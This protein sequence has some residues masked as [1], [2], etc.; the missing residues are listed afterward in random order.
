MTGTATGVKGARAQEA[1]QPSAAPCALPG[2]TPAPSARPCCSPGP[3]EPPLAPRGP[4]VARR[5]LRARPVAC[6]CSR[7]SRRQ[8]AELQVHHPK[9]LISVKMIGDRRLRSPRKIKKEFS[10]KWASSAKGTPRAQAPHPSTCQARSGVLA[11]LQGARGLPGGEENAPGTAPGAGGRPGSPP[12]QSLDFNGGKALCTFFCTHRHTHACTHTLFLFCGV[13]Y[14]RKR[15]T[16]P[17]TISP[18]VQF[19]N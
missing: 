13:I 4:G 6:W 2:R 18:Q 12:S 9:F 5:E 19:E 14:R 7:S 3:L 8:E 15:E 10:L 11:Q 1:G 16:S 17:M